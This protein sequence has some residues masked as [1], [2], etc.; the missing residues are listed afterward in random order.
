MKSFSFPGTIQGEFLVSLQIGKKKKTIK[1]QN[2]RPPEKYQLPTHGNQVQHFFFLYS[3]LLRTS[4]VIITSFRYRLR[5]DNII[6][7]HEA[8]PLI[9]LPWRSIPTWLIYACLFKIPIFINACDVPE[10][11]WMRD[12]NFFWHSVFPLSAGP[13]VRLWQDESLAMTLDQL[14]PLQESDIALEDSRYLTLLSSNEPNG[15]QPLPMLWW[16]VILFEYWYITISQYGKRD[17]T[18]HLFFPVSWFAST[19]PRSMFCFISLAI[20]LPSRTVRTSLKPWKEHPRL[21]AEM[22]GPW[23]ARN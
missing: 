8:Q 17:S 20:R 4:F 7:A 11:I 6:S 15:R 12:F 3:D 14:T 18:N 9:Y 2:R 21:A 16:K 10:R 23:W 19:C 1:K 5:S 13:E 22:W